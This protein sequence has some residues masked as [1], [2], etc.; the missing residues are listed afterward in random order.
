[1][2]MA[3]D[4]DGEWKY[5]IDEVGEDA[6]EHEGAE[7]DDPSDPEAT[8]RRIEPGSPSLENALFVALG[9]L[10]ALGV[11]ANGLGLL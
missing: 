4:S 6:T 9:A 10:L 8:D 5:G 2:T 1:M 7:T 11:I 3:S